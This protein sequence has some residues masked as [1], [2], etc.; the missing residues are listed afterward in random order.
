MESVG[1]D[2]IEGLGGGGNS[3]TQ[4]S[5]AD[6]VGPSGGVVGGLDRVLESLDGGRFC[7]REE[8]RRRGFANDVCDVLLCWTPD[9]PES[10]LPKVVDVRS[11][12]GWGFRYFTVGLDRVEWGVGALRA[13]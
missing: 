2:A 6:A 10:P 12:F 9:G 8:L 1:P 3:A 4:S 11:R 7:K 13:V 5:V